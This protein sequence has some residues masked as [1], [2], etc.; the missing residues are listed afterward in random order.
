[1]NERLTVIAQFVAKP[2]METAL[3][4]ALGALV[5]PSRSEAGCINYD[6]HQDNADPARFLLYENWVSSAA[7]EEHFTMLYL[8]QF[9]EDSAALLLEPFTMMR[10]RMLS[11]LV[12]L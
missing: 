1:M 5:A 3:A 6:L 7:L 9:L 4:Q 2:G 11:D 8:R 12:H 10:L